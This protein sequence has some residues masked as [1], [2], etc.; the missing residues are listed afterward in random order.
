MSWIV[1]I[2]GLVFAFRFANRRQRTWMGALLA[3]EVANGT[4]TEDELAVLEGPHKTKKHYLKSI[5][6]DKGKQAARNAGLV[7]EAQTDLAAA[8]A[9]TDDPSG[10]EATAAR[11]EV[12]RLRALSRLASDRASRPGEYA[13]SI[14]VTTICT[15][16]RN[17]LRDGDGAG[18][19]FR[20][21]R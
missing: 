6:K 16:V 20:M 14:V 5:R 1:G 8:I 12:A 3:D 2:T 19:T 17:A 18:P 10:P 11:A 21:A 13:G 9:A 15:D 4:I 7:L